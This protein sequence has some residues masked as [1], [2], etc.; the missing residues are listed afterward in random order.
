MDNRKIIP[1]PYGLASAYADF[2]EIHYLLYGDLR[3]KILNHER[4][5]KAT[6][7]HYTTNDLK[8][9]FASKNS[10]FKES[11]KFAVFHPECWVGFFPLMYSYFAKQ[12]TWNT[13]AM[14]PF[15]YFGLLFSVVVA[16][17]FK[18]IL[19]LGFFLM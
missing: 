19:K 4:R 5:H 18:F 2:I 14:I 12:M 17:F 11:L 6:D 16:G 1:V 13:S 8:N 10:Y 15:T 7:K 3:T 9:D